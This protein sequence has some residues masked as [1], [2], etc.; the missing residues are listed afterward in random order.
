MADKSAIGG[1]DPITDPIRLQI[2]QIRRSTRMA[3]VLQFPTS[4]E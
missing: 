3:C 2:T 1:V 4:A